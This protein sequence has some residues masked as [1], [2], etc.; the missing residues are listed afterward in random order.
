MCERNQIHFAILDHEDNYYSLEKT[1]RYINFSII[2]VNY[3]YDETGKEYKNTTLFE[4][5]DCNEEDFN[6]DED[7]KAYFKFK[8]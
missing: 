5:K 4:L 7:Q 1:R 2:H 8:I 3:T 6:G